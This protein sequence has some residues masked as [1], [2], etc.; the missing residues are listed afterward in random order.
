MKCTK[1]GV[2]KMWVKDSRN[3]GGEISRRREC[4]QCGFKLNTT[5]LP[6]SILRDVQRLANSNAHTDKAI[7]RDAIRMLQESL[8][9]D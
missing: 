2:G 3:T 6:T 9:R 1:C 8:D 5:E 4:D 7:I